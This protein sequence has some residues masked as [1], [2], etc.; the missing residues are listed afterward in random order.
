MLVGDLKGEKFTA[1]EGWQVVGTEWDIRKCYTL[2]AQADI[3]VGTESAIINSVAH[4]APLKMV[5]LSHSTAFQLTRDWERTIALEPDGLPC[6]PCHRIHV[7]WTHCAQDKATGS[8]VCQAAVTAE[9]V[10]DYA[11]QWLRGEIGEK[12]LQADVL[13]EV[14]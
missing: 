6:Y 2:A 4:E 5:L 14:A 11:M 12:D 9:I 8:A 13:A 3:V 1:P 7:S 10:V